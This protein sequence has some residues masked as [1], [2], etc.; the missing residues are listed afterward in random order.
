[1][2]RDR[3]GA[4]VT[5]NQSPT[6]QSWDWDHS[7]QLEPKNSGPVRLGGWPTWT[8]KSL[9]VYSTGKCS[10]HEPHEYLTSSPLFLSF[11][12][13]IL[14]KDLGSCFLRVVWRTW[15]ASRPRLALFLIS[16]FHSKVIYFLF[17]HLWGGQIMGRKR[18]LSQRIVGWEGDPLMEHLGS[19]FHEPV[20]VRCQGRR[21]YCKDGQVPSPP[22]ELSVPL[23]ELKLSLGQ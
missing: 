19:L 12:V 13:T 17:I 2:E 4:Y 9:P 23:A 5:R 14:I 1:M 21:A 3:F 11:L 10:H 7:K 8:W 22:Q 18:L 6:W 20:A 15:D 16:L